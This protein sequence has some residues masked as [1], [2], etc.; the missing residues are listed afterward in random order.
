MSILF[1]KLFLWLFLVVFIHAFTLSAQDTISAPKKQKNNDFLSRVDFGGY[2]GLQFGTYT[3]VEISP[4]ASYRVTE[5]FHAGLGLTYQY[6]RINYSNAPDYRTSSYGGSLFGRYFI[7]RDLF[8][9]AEYAPLYVTYYDYYYDNSGIYSYRNEGSAWVHDFLIGGGYRQWIG[10]NASINMMILWNINET[11]Y[12]PY[13]NPI[14]RIG[15]G[16]GL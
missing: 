16:V 6:Y 9:H 11:Y 15:F 8:A 4:L 1:K 10:T 14:I 7:W 3:L 5:S 13:R 12:S 2:L